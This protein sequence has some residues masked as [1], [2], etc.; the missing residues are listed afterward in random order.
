MS[1]LQK[2]DIWIKDAEGFRTMHKIL[3]KV[4]TCEKPN[5]EILASLKRSVRVYSALPTSNRR[6]VG[7]TE[8]FDG[9][10]MHPVDVYLS[11]LPEYITTAH[12]AEDWMWQSVCY[13][14]GC[15]GLVKP[16][17]RESGRFSAYV[18]VWR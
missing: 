12:D 10:H 5:A 17:Q 2:N 16:F 18:C 15:V 8:A 1:Q 7:R 6:Y 4:A 9:D 14:I 11:D 13:N 3:H